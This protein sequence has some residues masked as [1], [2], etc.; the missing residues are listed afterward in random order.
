[1]IPKRFPDWE[2][3]M[4]N[5]GGKMQSSVQVVAEMLAVALGLEKDL[6]LKMAENG[7]HLLAP[8]GTDLKEYG[9]VNTVLA[10]FHT[11]LKLTQ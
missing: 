11:Y 7:P 6:F 5:W 10:G 3:K 8:T 9:T 2:L 4:N 1:V